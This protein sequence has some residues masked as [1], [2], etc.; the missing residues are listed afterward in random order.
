MWIYII[1]KQTALCIIKNKLFYVTINELIIEVILDLWK[2]TKFEF[3]LNCSRNASFLVQTS[4]IN[5]H[6]YHYNYECNQCQQVGAYI[7]TCMIH[8]AIFISD[9]MMLTMN[10]VVLSL[11]YWCEYL[12]SYTDSKFGTLNWSITNVW[13]MNIDTLIIW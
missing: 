11:V 1:E 4:I 5:N 3:I 8:L 2:L 9:M 6:S 10:R 12:R 7:M 13:I